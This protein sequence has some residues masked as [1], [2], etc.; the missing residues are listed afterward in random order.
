[1]WGERP[2]VWCERPGRSDKEER[3]PTAA[4]VRQHRGSIHIASKTALAA[5]RFSIIVV[6]ILFFIDNPSIDWRGKHYPNLIM[7]KLNGVHMLSFVKSK[8][9]GS[10]NGRQIKK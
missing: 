8:R 2:L 7:T 3:G 4:Q 5:S 6:L 9:G 10:V 1:M